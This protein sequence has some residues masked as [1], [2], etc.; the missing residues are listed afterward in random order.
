MA[1]GGGGAQS[2][3][4]YK[5]QVWKERENQTEVLL[6]TSLTPYHKDQADLEECLLCFYLSF[7]NSLVGVVCFNTSKSFLSFLGAA[8]SVDNDQLIQTICDRSPEPVYNSSGK[9]LT[10]AFRQGTQGGR[11]WFSMNYTMVEP[12]DSE[13]LP[14]SDGSLC[15]C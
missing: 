6:L 8:S 9:Y 15:F 1:A 13:W 4:V 14:V 11:R 3:S 12:V 7:I 5:P 2:D 10:V